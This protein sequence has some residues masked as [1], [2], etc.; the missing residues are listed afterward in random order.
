M[1]GMDPD[2]DPKRLTLL[3]HEILA[4]SRGTQGKTAQAASA[5]SPPPPPKLP[6]KSRLQRLQQM[7]KSTRYV[8]ESAHATVPE[9]PHEKV[10]S[11]RSRASTTV[12][13]TRRPAR[14]DSIGVGAV[15]THEEDS[16]PQPSVAVRDGE[17]WGVFKP[18]GSLV[19][20][21]SHVTLCHDLDGGLLMVK[22]CKH[23]PGREE[24]D[25]LRRLH[26][27]RNV[28]QL[29]ICFETEQKTFL[30]YEF[31]RVTLLEIV[32]V[33]LPLREQHLQI[34]ASEV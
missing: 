3:H 14:H 19:I 6:T 1:N 26:A 13:E 5:P 9:V 15:T 4:Q 25:L 16:K 24:R 30:G 22:E 17:P 27:H 23:G 21:G 18:L 29:L 10:S 32:H 34:I 2:P 12:S 33:S 20:A 11:L 28:M 31:F 8:S 7:G